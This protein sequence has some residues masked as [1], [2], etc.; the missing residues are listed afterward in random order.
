MA[1]TP[2]VRI[3][4]IGDLVEALAPFTSDHDD[5]Y[6]YRGQSSSRWE[7]QPKVG[8]DRKWKQNEHELL[9]RFKQDAARTLP[10]TPQSKWEW[11]SLAQHYGL[12]T[13]LLDWTESPLIALFFACQPNPET[14]S[15]DGTFWVLNPRTFNQ[16]FL[17]GRQSLVMLDEDSEDVDQF[18]P[19][20]RQTGIRE[21]VLPEK[22]DA[23]QIAAIIPRSFDRITAQAGTFTI[24]RD[25]SAPLGS[26]EH[27]R[28]FMIPQNAKPTILLDLRALNIH[29]G[30]VLPDPSVITSNLR[31]DY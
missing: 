1:V 20:L 14:D 17:N 30:T 5:I 3:E 2:E 16:A 7:L 11:L 25:P 19:S 23:N 28:Q 21:S 31:G 12:P 29:T 6:W 9:I 15:E 8:R 10:T 4:S 27:L 22:R 24:T 26:S 13:R 18:F